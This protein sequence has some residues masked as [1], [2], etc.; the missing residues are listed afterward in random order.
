MANID[1]KVPAK[2][3]IK[4]TSTRAISFIPYRENFAS[5]LAAGKTFEFPV[6][7]AGQVFYYLKQATEGLE[8][9]QISAFDEASADIL[10]YETP[11]LMTISNTSDLIKS[12]FPYKENFP[13][14][15]NPE[16][17][18]VVEVSTVGQILYYMA[19]ATKGLTVTYAKKTVS[20]GG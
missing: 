8:V 9:S 4:N 10:V 3:K 2:I 14:E 6:D 12:F 16:D 1:V 17:S 18:Y 19:Q 7:R 13:V 20:P 5:T 15:V 11:A